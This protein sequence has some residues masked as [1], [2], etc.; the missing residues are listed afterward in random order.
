MEN[1]KKVIVIG[2]VAILVLGGIAYAAFGDNERNILES[3]ATTV[4]IQE[5]TLEIPVAQSEQT[6]IVLKQDGSEVIGTGAVV[7]GNK[8]TIQQPG[9]YSVSGSLEEG[10]IFVDAGKKD[11]VIL[12]FNGVTLSNSSEEALYADKVGHLSVQLAEGSENVIQSGEK[13]DVTQVQVDADLQG[14]ALQSKGNLSITGA[15]SLKVYG[16]INNGIQAK[17]NLLIDS[18]TITVEACNHGLKGADS[19]AIS[20]GEFSVISGG[21]GMKSDNETEEEYGNIAIS[22]GS[23]KIESKGDAVQAEHALAIS[24]GTFDVVTGGGSETVSYPENSMGG[25]FNRDDGGFGGGGQRPGHG[26]RDDRNM[27]S[28]TDGKK[29]QRPDRGG[30]DMGMQQM[31]FRQ[32][33]TTEEKETNWD[34]SDESGESRKGFKSGTMLVISGGTFTVDTYDDAFHTN[35]SM[36]ISGGEFTVASGDD[37]FHAD[38]ELT[39]SGGSLT[40]TRSYEGIEANQ[41]TID[42]A[43]IQITAMDDGINAYGGQRSMGGGSTKKTEEMPVLQILGGMLSIDAGGDGLD[44]NGDL[45]IEGGTVIVNGPTDNGNGALDSGSEN[46]GICT[47]SGGTV[48]ALGSS[49]MA[50]GFSSAS[51]QCSFLCNLSTS[52]GEGS[53]IVI[54]DSKGKEIYQYTAAKTGNSIVFSSPELKQGETYVLRVDG[55]ETEISMDSVSVTS[56]ESRGGWGGRGWR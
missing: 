33:E 27:P 42:K 15:G 26:F 23:F 32:T 6:K 8:V 45:L 31:S 4:N 49:G 40:V 43:E 36:E 34:M 29:G 14:A 41:I 25:K 38:N 28:D 3:Q 7:T 44:S 12:V 51:K 10:Q 1:K 20:G 11:T 55:Q 2:A 46:G 13:V 48:L 30:R 22:G 35:T 19:I 47:I 37:G 16:Y 52:Y 18:G 21:D 56:G 54:L 50:E 24:G 17:N 53:E 9:T 5:S 39:I